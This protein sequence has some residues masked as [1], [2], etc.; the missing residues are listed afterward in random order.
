MDSQTRASL[1]CALSQLQALRHLSSYS[2]DPGIL[3]QRYL[4]M[5]ALIYFPGLFKGK[6]LRE[7]SIMYEPQP[8]ARCCSGRPAS[9]CPVQYVSVFDTFVQMK[10]LCITRTIMRGLCGSP[11]GSIGWNAGVT[12]NN[13]ALLFS[14]I[15]FGVVAGS[16]LDLDL[17]IG[18]SRRLQ[19]HGVYLTGLSDVL[20]TYPIHR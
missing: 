10:I 19:D 11:T 1:A 12:G 16:G 17:S 20:L 13:I 6:R 3:P 9:P 4:N 18:T 14:L 15:V 5:N 2:R 7:A 8:I